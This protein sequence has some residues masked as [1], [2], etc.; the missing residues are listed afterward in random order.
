MVGL[1]TLAA[2]YL[3]GVVLTLYEQTRTTAVVNLIAAVINVVLDVVLVGVLNMGIIAPAIATSAALLFVAG[4]F[5]VRARAV[6]AIE[7]RPDAILAVPL[8]LALAATLILGGIAGA[9]VGIAGSLA[10][11]TAILRWRSPIGT[12]DARLIGRLDLPGFVKR[13]ALKAAAFSG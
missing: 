1:A 5:Y 2:A 12:E 11:S 13:A 9:V 7:A 8:I 10:A 4:G 3:V 6:L